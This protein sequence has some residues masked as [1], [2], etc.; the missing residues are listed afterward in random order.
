MG[1]TYSATPARVGGSGPYTW[2]LAS[3]TLPS[4][5]SLDRCDRHH[6]RHADGTAGTTAGLRL[7]VTDSRGL[8]ATSAPLALT[9]AK[10]SQ[11]VSFTSTPPV[12]AVAG[13]TT[14]TPTAVATSGLAVALSIDASATSVCTIS[15]GI[16]SFTATGTCV[17]DA[18]QPGSAD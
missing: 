10:G 5:A 12:S 11:S 13:V 1:T 15:A 18:D 9:V 6:L 17:I 14:Y 3:G 8:T 7:T 2:S 16:V 4:W